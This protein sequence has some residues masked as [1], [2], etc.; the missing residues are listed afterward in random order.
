LTHE[1]FLLVILSLVPVLAEARA[2]AA[3]QGHSGSF[4]AANAQGSN[5]ALLVVLGHG[6]GQR[7]D[8]A[9]AG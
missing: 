2:L 3:L 4:A 8:Q 5:A 1:F 6:M 9:A 7:D